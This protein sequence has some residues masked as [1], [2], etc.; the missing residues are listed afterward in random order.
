[1]IERAV[2]C[3][4]GAVLTLADQLDAPAPARPASPS[5]RSLTEVE[6]EHIL[7]ALHESRWQIEGEQG[8]A[9]LLGLNPS[10]LR[11]RM[12]KLGIHRP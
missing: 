4:Q 2:I 7:Q 5:G 12:R 11:G 10:T 3:T 1:V 8:A 6:R 9:A